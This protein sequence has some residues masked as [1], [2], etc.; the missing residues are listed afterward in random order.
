VS[1]YIQLGG[2][3]RAVYLFDTRLVRLNANNAKS[4]LFTIALVAIMLLLG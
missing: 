2:P 4:F 3:E 1:D